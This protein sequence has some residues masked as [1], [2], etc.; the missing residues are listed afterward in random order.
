MYKLSIIAF[1]TFLFILNSNAQNF[2]NSELVMKQ[3]FENHLF[4]KHK[5]GFLKTKKRGFIRKYNPIALT[6]GGLMYFYQ[7]VI[8]AQ[9]GSNCPY[10]ISCSGFSKESIKEFGLLK[11]VAL[12]ADRLTRCNE[13]ILMDLKSFNMNLNNKIID[14]PS[15]YKIRNYR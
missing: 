5:R 6:F 10:E 3:N 1:F 12:S 7:N 2:T 9:L 11:G 4:H 8:S 13:F 14:S 15:K